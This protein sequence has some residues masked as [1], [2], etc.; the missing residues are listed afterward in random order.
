MYILIHTWLNLNTKWSIC[1]RISVAIATSLLG[2]LV[3]LSVG[4]CL[5]T[6]QTGPS[7]CT[8][9]DK[10]LSS[11]T[12]TNKLVHLVAHIQTNFSLVVHVQTNWSI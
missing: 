1:V 3:N 8:D 10:L 11:C 7:S 9:T 6:R 5:C 12:R 2:T 4:V